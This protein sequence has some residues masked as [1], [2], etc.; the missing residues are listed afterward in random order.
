MRLRRIN[1]RW[2]QYP[3]LLVEENR[4]LAQR[5]GVKGRLIDLGKE[6]MGP[7]PELLEEII[8]LIQEDAQA[9]GCE[10][11]IEHARKIAKEG[12]SADRQMACYHDAIE[13]G[14]SPDLAMRGVVDLMVRETSEGL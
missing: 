11:E 8:E 7:F 2:R 6:Q 14:V 4:W 1:Q 9:L 13:K 10:A 12:T 5:H 3:R